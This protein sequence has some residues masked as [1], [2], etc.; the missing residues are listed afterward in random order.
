MEFQV[1]MFRRINMKNNKI[2]IRELLWHGEIP[3]L[4]VQPGFTLIELLIV[5][6]IIGILTTLATVNYIGVRERARDA[7]RKSDLSQIQTALEFYRTDNNQYPAT[8]P[9]GGSLKTTE[10]TYLNKIPCDPSNTTTEY[11]YLPNT[12]NYLT[13][14]LYGCIENKNDK[15][16][17][18]LSAPPNNGSVCTSGKYYTVVNP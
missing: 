6:V 2:G 15:D 14:T 1:R 9:C 16:T 3:T 18:I 12:T 8:L 17:K 13:Y 5:I 11:V 10:T 4:G 7:Q